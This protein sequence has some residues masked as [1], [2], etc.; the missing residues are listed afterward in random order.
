MKIRVVSEHDRAAYKVAGI[1]PN[2]PV[3]RERLR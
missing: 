2:P 1:G 3:L